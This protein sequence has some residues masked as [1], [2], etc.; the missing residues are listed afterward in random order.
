MD[1]VVIPMWANGIGS[2]CLSTSKPFSSRSHNLLSM[3][4]L[5]MNLGQHSPEYILHE[6]VIVCVRVC[7]CLLVYIAIVTRMIV[8]WR[9]VLYERNWHC[10]TTWGRGRE[11]N[12]HTALMLLLLL[13]LLLP[14]GPQAAKW[15]QLQATSFIVF[16]GAFLFPHIYIVLHVYSPC[17]YSSYLLFHIS[18]SILWL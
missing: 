8:W 2:R 6:F 9:A 10:N 16:S 13:L 12:W 18:Y 4:R 1:I 5:I 15:T 17:M 14:T 11:S 7:V 3:L